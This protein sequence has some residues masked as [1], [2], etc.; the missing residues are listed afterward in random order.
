LTRKQVLSNWDDCF[1]AIVE[2]IVL[3]ISFRSFFQRFR[4][5]FPPL[6]FDFKWTRDGRE[7]WHFNQS[8][9]STDLLMRYRC[10]G[11]VSIDL[12]KK[13]RIRSGTILL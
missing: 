13:D 6:K 3:L 1:K 10:V 2:L 8:C 4:V 7:G 9:Q 11:K 5:H 12:S